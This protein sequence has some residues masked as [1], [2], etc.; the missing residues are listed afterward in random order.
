MGIS[1]TMT[2]DQF[3]RRRERGR[4]ERSSCRRSDDAEYLPN[5]AGEIEAE[6][7]SKSATLKGPNVGFGV[8][9]RAVASSAHVVTAP[10]LPVVVIRS[11]QELGGGAEP[12]QVIDISH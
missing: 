4:D 7:S 3:M 12:V 10:A 8:A 11:Q 1:E 9:M 2:C 6:I 5:I